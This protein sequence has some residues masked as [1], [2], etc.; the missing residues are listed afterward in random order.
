MT[1]MHAPRRSSERLEGP[2]GVRVA[3]GAAQAR[4]IL[5]ER[6]AALTLDVTDRDPDGVV[7]ACVRS[8]VGLAYRTPGFDVQVSA[9]AGQGWSVRLHHGADGLHVQL[10]DDEDL[11]LRDVP[12]TPLSAELDAELAALLST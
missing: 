8:L 4:P 2:G 1:T 6:E 7:R 12:L 9:G 11:A 10:V 5:L 3:A